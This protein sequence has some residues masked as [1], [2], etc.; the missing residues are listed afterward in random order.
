MS[1]ARGVCYLNGEFLP[2]SE[3]RVSV[4]DRGFIF[5]DAVYEVIPVHAGTP[6]AL[7]EH[8]ARLQRNLA[9]VEIANPLSTQEWHDVLGRL[10]QANDGG[11]LSLYVQVTRGVAPRDHA[12]PRDITPTV[13]AMASRR[14]AASRAGQVTAITLEDCRWSRCDIKSTSLIGNVLLRNRAIAAGAYEALLLRDGWV[15]EG[16]ASNVFV[17]SE[18]AVRTPPLSG[19]ILPGVTRALLIAVLH[20]QGIPM[21]ESRIA[22]GELRAADEIWITSSSR[23]LLCVSELDGHAVG[24][25]RSYP[26]AERA[27]AAFAAYKAQRCSLPQADAPPQ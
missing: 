3:A 1:A 26:V 25:G 22:A 16:A 2:L 18:G 5:G 11:D 8:V 13:F 4:L 19:A 15:T 27:L 12:F 7:E 23:D 17:V 21:S 9:E 24:D 14:S 6:F 10:V 20:Q